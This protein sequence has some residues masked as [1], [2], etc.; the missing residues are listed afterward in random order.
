MILFTFKQEVG[1]YSVSPQT[2]LGFIKYK[3]VAPK[4]LIKSMNLSQI[5][6]VNINI[7]KLFI[8]NAG[9]LNLHIDYI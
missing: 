1:L 5:N 7:H 8:L 9:W 2:I 3:N 4:A 6:G